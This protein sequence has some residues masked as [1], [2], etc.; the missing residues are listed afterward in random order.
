LAAAPTKS[1]CA[2]ASAGGSS[3]LKGSAVLG[4]ASTTSR[5][6]LLAPR[7]ALFL[8]SLY[9]QEEGRALSAN[10]FVGVSC[11]SA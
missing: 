1:H 5:S 3:L 9:V 10:R 8:H 4:D 11:F 7:S 2:S 6:S